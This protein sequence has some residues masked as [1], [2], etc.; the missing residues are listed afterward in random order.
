MQV[1]SPFESGIRDDN[2]GQREKFKPS[3]ELRSWGS[4]LDANDNAPWRKS[5]VLRLGAGV[6]QD[7][8]RTL[9]DTRVMRLVPRHRSQ[10]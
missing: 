7:S 8:R 1:L 3:E 2:E 6:A 4:V 10:F 9:E 5:N